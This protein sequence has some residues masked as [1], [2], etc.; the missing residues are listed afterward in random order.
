MQFDGRADERACVLKVCDGTIAT[1]SEFFA[2]QLCAPLGVQAPRT[3]LLRRGHADW[4]GLRAAAALVP[5][6]REVVSQLDEPKNSVMLLMTLV[7]GAP[8]L[9]NGKAMSPEGLPMTARSFG[10]LLVLDMLLHNEDRLPCSD[11]RWRDNPGNMLAD[12]Q[13]AEVYA[14]D[15][16]IPRLPPAFVLE[17]AQKAYPRFV[18]ALLSPQ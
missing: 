4:E 7:P 10:Q 18:N 11:L 9:R 15:T 3:R 8:V 6:G 12:H 13:T 1:H 17:A 14:I 16:T 2:T 5:G